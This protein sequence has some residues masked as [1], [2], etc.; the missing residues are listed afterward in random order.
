VFTA[1]PSPAT[2]ASVREALRLIQA[3]PQLRTKLWANAT[4][5][6]QGLKQLGFELG[7]DLSPIVAIRMPTREKTLFAWKALLDHG[8]YVNLVFPPAAPAGMS[9]L[10]CSVSAAHSSE[11]IN[12]ILQAFAELQPLA[13]TPG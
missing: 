4:L 3:K 9:L 13:N 2:I 12:T 1:S 7:P 6:Y 11:Q 5:L 8:I 10:R